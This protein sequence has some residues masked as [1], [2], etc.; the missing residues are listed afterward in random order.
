MEAILLVTGG[1]ILFLAL[2]RWLPG[3]ATAPGPAVASRP[4]EGAT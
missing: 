1:P 3:G 4:A 2:L